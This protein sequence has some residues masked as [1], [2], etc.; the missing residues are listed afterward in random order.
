MPVKQVKRAGL[1]P[2]L[3]A[4]AIAAPFAIIRHAVD[5]SAGR[6]IGFGGND[7]AISKLAH[8]DR[9]GRFDPFIGVGVDLKIPFMH[10]MRIDPGQQGKIAR[11][12][13]P[14]DMMRIGVFLGLNDSLAQAVHLRFSAPVK[15]RQIAVVL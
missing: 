7:P 6:N 8:A 14:L 4:D 3:G 5:V 2:R 13:Q 9:I 12:H 1:L 11:Y 15:G 10:L